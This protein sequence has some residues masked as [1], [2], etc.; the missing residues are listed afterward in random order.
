MALRFRRSVKIAPG[1]RLNFGKRGM[2]MSAGVRGATMTFGARGV[3]G[4]VGLPGT[5]LS[6][7]TKLSGGSRSTRSSVQAQDKSVAVKLVLDL[8]EKGYPFAK[9]QHGNELPKKYVKLAFEQNPGQLDAW[10]RKECAKLNDEVQSILDIHLLT[11]AP[12]AFSVFP[13][14]P[15]PEDRPLMPVLKSLSFW[16][17]LFPFWRRRIEA[18]NARRTAG[19]EE[20]LAK[21][22]AAKAVFEQ[23]KVQHRHDF[24]VGRLEDV[25]VMER[26]L[27]EV[28]QEI[29]WP[30]ETLVDF[31]IAQDGTKVMVDVD[32]PEIEDLPDTT[33]EIGASGRKINFKKRSQAQVRRDYMAH[34]HGIG[35]RMLGTIFAALPKTTEVVLSGYSQ[36]NDG[37]T[38][39]VNDEYLYSVRV[40]REAWERINFDNLPQVE[41]VECLGQF[42]IIRDMTKTGVFKAVVPMAK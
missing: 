6:Y 24:E 41:V 23:E 4:N 25:A 20:Q 17:R 27:E 16:A 2:S 21:W 19:H 30:R 5:G 3:Y 29:G 1:L 22:E 8:D 39:T 35:F 37:A 14:E 38:G 9:D 12:D 28:L 15:F 42:E 36:R 13:D 11:P 40:K 10:M 34:V 32:L 7:R 26:F 33:A 18:E 31:D